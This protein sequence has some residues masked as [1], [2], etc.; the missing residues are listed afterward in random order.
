M[1]A[2][3]PAI[4][5]TSKGNGKQ[6]GDDV[7][8]PSYALKNLL[9]IGSK[10]AAAARGVCPP[11]FCWRKEKAKSPGGGSGDS[12]PQGY[13]TMRRGTL[14]GPLVLKL[15]RFPF[16]AYRPCG[17]RKRE[18]LAFCTLAYGRAPTCASETK[19]CHTRFSFDIAG[20][21]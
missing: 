15:P 12:V 14:L 8:E 13:A 16:P 17:K 5:R 9:S 20:A 21:D 1:P 6:G 2:Q 19:L 4:G 3:I 7:S 10:P 11:P 18:T